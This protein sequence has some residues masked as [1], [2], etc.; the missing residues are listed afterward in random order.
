MRLVKCQYCEQLINR[1][2]EGFEKINNKYYHTKCAI[3]V[4]DRKE[5][6]DYISELFHLK[7]PGPVNLKLIKTYHDTNNYSYKS[8]LY[9][10]KYYYEVMNGKVE[11]ANNRIGII[12]YIYDEAK[13]YYDNLTKTQTVIAKNIEKIEK[14]L[15]KETNSIIVNKKIRK[16]HT[17][18]LEELG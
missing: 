12:P 10:L 8:M 9:T 14:E 17:I 2:E 7:A 16:K 3:E 11:K 13:T 6:Y 5:L 1:E 18:D 15:N 4:N